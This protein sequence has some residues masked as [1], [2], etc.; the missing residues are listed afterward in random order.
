MFPEKWCF[1]IP[2]PVMFVCYAIVAFNSRSGAMPFIPFL[3][4]LVPSPFVYALLV[5]LCFLIRSFT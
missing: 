1:F 4:L 3:A 2:L 5:G